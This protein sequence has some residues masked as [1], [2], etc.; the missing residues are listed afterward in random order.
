MMY[1]RL[2]T[3]C[4]IFVGIL[5][6]GSLTGQNTRH[7]DGRDDTVPGEATAPY[8]TLRNIAV[9]WEIRGDD[10]LNGRVSVR[11]RTAGDGEWNEAMPLRRVPGCTWNNR[12]SD[13]PG[14]SWKN[15]H[16]GSIF[17]L[18]PDTRYEIDLQLQDPDGGDR[19]A[20]HHRANT[21]RSRSLY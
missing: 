7:F 6:A 12:E 3:I 9:E 16:S 14:I 19:P 18:Q 5:P 2:S 13:G 8:P 21:S 11:Y 10:N 15:R 17:D 1:Q 20:R 4:L